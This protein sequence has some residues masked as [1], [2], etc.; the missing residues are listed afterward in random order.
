MLRGRATAG[1]DELL[2]RTSSGPASANSAGAER[3]PRNFPEVA[4]AVQR[5]RATLELDGV[6]PSA[7]IDRVV[8][9]L[10]G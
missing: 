4:E 1:L 7:L 3:V 5:H 8:G 6:F 9:R 10:R 2:R